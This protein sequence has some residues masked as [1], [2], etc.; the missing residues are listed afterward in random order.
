MSS[1]F[2]IKVKM[3][4][5]NKIAKNHGL[6]RDGRVTTF[7][8]DTVERIYVDKNGKVIIEFLNGCRISKEDSYGNSSTET[9]NSY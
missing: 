9:K 7:L 1:G 4:S 5:A 8:R 3:N 6:N 2:S